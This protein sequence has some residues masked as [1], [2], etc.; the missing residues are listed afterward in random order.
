MLTSP[1]L[2]HISMKRPLALQILLVLVLMFTQ[3][4]GATHLSAHAAATIAQHQ[5]VDRA[6]LQACEQCSLFTALGSSP[7]E[8]PLHFDIE[9]PRE[10]LVA[11]AIHSFRSHSQICYRSRAPPLLF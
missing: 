2:A 10:Q 8:T 7:P 5:S 3:H 1:R 6:T 9:P 11:F 4:V